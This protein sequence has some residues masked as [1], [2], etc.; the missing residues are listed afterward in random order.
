MIDTE[1][2]KKA[3]G[4]K[5]PEE[6]IKL[7]KDNNIELT[8][9]EAKEYI[10]SLNKTGELGDDELDSVSG[11]GCQMKVNGVRY[12]VVTS[13]LKCFTGMYREAVL[14]PYRTSAARADWATF[15]SKGCC[16]KCEFLELHNCIGYCSKS[17]G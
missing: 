7:A 8:K 9:E 3:K 6:L 13:G 14:N 1:L 17:N 16:G 10:A 15:S 2:I 11:G 4:I 5:S 12:T